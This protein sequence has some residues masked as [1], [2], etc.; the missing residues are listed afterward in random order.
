MVYGF[1]KTGTKVNKTLA[2][3]INVFIIGYEGMA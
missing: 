3:C 2:I 1:S